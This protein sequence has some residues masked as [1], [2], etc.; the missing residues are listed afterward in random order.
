M[1]IM[2]LEAKVMRKQ[3]EADNMESYTSMMSHEFLT[4]LSTAIMLLGMLATV[5]RNN[6]EANEMLSVT[7]RALNFLLSLVNDIV[8]LRLVKKGKIVPKIKLFNPL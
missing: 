1:K 7:T 6:A 5:V 2:G 8:D 3:S 4:P